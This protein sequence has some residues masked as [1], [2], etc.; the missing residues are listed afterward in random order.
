M[1]NLYLVPRLRMDGAEGVP[2]V[3]LIPLNS[4]GY[5]TATLNIN[6]FYV[7]S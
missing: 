4:S 3:V 2:N 5:F 1:T 6:K 7:L